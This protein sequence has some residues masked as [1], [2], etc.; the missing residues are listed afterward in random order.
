MLESWWVRQLPWWEGRVFQME[1]GR[2]RW[3][4][5]R[6]SKGGGE[7]LPRKIELVF[8]NFNLPTVR[9]PSRIRVM[10][11]CLITGKSNLATNLVPEAV[12]VKQLSSPRPL[13]SNT[14]RP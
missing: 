13:A 11:A 4:Y 1:M 8:L 5:S 6:R 12:G 14:S 7:P 9:C 3:R 2:W 10:F